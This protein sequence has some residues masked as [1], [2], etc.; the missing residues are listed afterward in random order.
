MLQVV[1][2]ANN[3]LTTELAQIKAEL[4]KLNK[5][6][7]IMRAKLIRELSTIYTACGCRY[8]YR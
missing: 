5:E 4:V 2:Q 6:H 1:E 8:R 7:K 3:D